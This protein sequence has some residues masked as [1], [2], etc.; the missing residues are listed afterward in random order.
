MN[1]F[2][3][4]ILSRSSRFVLH[5]AVLPLLYYVND[6][7]ML[8]RRINAVETTTLRKIWAEAYANRV[9]NF[10]VKSWC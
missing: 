1:L 9:R 10:G 3:S 7:R 5:N 6:S 8:E 4:T 2:Q